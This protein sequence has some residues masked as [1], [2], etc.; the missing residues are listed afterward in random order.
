MNQP[1]AYDA[2]L[3]GQSP[4]KNDSTVL[5]GIEGLQQQMKNAPP[6]ERSQVI[7]KQKNYDLLQEFCDFLEMG[8]F[9]FVHEEIIDRSGFFTADGEAILC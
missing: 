1:Q 8:K 7:K 4:L 9:A 3:G 2:I 5:G 6:N